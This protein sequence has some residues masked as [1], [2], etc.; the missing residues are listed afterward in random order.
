MILIFVSLLWAYFDEPPGCWKKSSVPCAVRTQKKVLENAGIALSGGSS[1][2]RVGE[3]RWKF[4]SGEMLVKS[5]AILQTPEREIAIEGKIRLRKARVTAP[6]EIFNFD[7]RVQGPGL[8]QIPVGFKNWVGLTNRLGEVEQ[9]VP[10]P[11]SRENQQTVEAASTL[12]QE[13]LQLRSIASQ[14]KEK[15]RQRQIQQQKQ[16][17]E[18]IRKVFRQRFFQPELD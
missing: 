6:L 3:D 7:G 14:E 18:H 15:K 10:E 12:Y 13:S 2:L 8:L 1:A 17:A 11:I 9:G 16:E 5:K 4:L